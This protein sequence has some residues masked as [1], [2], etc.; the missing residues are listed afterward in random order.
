MV[1]RCCDWAKKWNDID[2]LEYN[3]KL[4]DELNHLYK[5]ISKLAI[6]CLR[7][8]IPLIIENP[9]NGFHYLK[10]YWCLK[11]KII[12]MNRTQNGDY[13]DK[14]TQYWFINCEPKDNIIFEPL[15]YVPHKSIKSQ[16]NENGLNRQKAR[17]MIHPQYANRFIRQ[18]ILEED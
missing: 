4:H 5:L 2:K 11:P 16:K 15:E 7:K 3:L 10:T 1:S 18:F 6:I 9:Y 17:S 13:Y 14:P 12:D 8:N